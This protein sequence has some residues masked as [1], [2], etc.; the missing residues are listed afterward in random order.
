MNSSGDDSNRRGRLWDKLRYAFRVKPREP[1]S[2]E[3]LEL[4]RKVAGKIHEKGIATPAILALESVR[5]LNFLGSQVMVA[6]EPVV[7]MVI[8]IP[9][10]NRF[11]AI[12][13]RRDGFE[14]LIENLEKLEDN[15]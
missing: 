15:S 14:L 10:Y 3:D 13:E 7:K 6:I 11:S 12:M 5:P 2:E 9:E 8:S 1:L 4:I